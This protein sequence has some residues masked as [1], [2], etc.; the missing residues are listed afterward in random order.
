MILLILQ[1]HYTIL[2]NKQRNTWE[3]AIRH[4]KQKQAKN[5]HISKIRKSSEDS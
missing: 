3:C 5:I 4:A 2:T 1:K